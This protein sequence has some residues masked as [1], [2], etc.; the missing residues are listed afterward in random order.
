MQ[1]KKGPFGYFAV[2]KLDSPD[3]LC[4]YAEEVIAG[5]KSDFYLTPVTEFYGSGV[6]CCY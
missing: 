1:I 2:E 4:S 3:K 6:M 5:N